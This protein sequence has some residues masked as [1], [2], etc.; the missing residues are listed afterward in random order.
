MTDSPVDEDV[1]LL[2]QAREGNTDALND[3]M[4]RHRD[5]LKRMVKLRLNPMLQGRVDDSDIMQDAY[6]EAAKRFPDYVADPKA[7][8]FLWMRQIVGHKIIDIHRVHLDAERR[9]ADREISIN[10]D[11]GPS[12][13]STCLAEKLLGR[14]SSPSQAVMR[15]ENRLMLEDTLNGMEEIDREVLALRHF[16]QLTNA[17]IANVLGIDKSTASKR[18]V[19]ALGRLKTI[20]EEMPG[21]LRQSNEEDE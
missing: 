12:A 10:R 17:E 7:P 9:A 15:A 2:A 6:L 5:R 11:V 1:Q 18:Y 20:L 16:E 21:F 4:M 13:N 3:L 19:R 14:L 8:F